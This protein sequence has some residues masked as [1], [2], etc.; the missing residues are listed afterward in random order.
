MKFVSLFCGCENGVDKIANIKRKF[1][2]GI[3][4]AGCGYG[5]IGLVGVSMFIVCGKK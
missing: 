4:I 3:S 2:S 5:V 1:R